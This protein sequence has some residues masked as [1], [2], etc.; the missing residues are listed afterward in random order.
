MCAV[1]EYGTRVMFEDN[2]HDSP[3]RVKKIEARLLDDA[4]RWLKEQPNG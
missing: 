3:Y 4:L 1:H 2:G